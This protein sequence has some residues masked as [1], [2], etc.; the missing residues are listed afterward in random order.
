MLG[1]DSSKLDS[2]KKLNLDDLKLKDL[3][4]QMDI[5]NVFIHKPAKYKIELS[6]L[7]KKE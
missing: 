3:D 1:V 4:S 6:K 2:I 5:V 7:S